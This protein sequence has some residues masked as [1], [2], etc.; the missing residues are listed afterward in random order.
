MASEIPFQ[1]EIP[2]WSMKIRQRVMAVT[3][4]ATR[5]VA[6][7]TV[8]LVIFSI[9]LFVVLVFCLGLQI[10]FLEAASRAGVFPLYGFFGGNLFLVISFVL[11]AVSGKFFSKIF[12]PTI[13]SL[14][15]VSPAAGNRVS[16]GATKE[17]PV[18]LLI[19]RRQVSQKAQSRS[20]DA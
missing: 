1:L 2:F 4:T 20:A 10:V 14:R 5:F 16:S 8:A 15:V 19:L 6:G 13:S 3:S 12:G 17:V 9:S 11:V 18:V 7:T